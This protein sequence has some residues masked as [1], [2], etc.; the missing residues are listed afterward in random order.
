MKIVLTLKSRNEESNIQRAIESYH[1]WVDEILLADG[2]STDRTVELASQYCK[3]SVRP[4][5]EYYRREDGSL[6][7]H[8]GRHLNFLF[9]WADCVGADWIIHDDCDC[10]LNYLMKQDGRS[11][12]EACTNQTVHVCRLYVYGQDRYFR[13]MTDFAGGWQAGLWAWRADTGLR[14]KDVKR[15]FTVD[16]INQYSKCNIYPPH[17]ILHRFAP[18]EEVIQRKI[19][20]YKLEEPNATHPKRH[21]GEPEP[22]PEWARE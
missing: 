20:D 12:I 21:Y 10:S 8:E 18:T 7:N 4:F 5:L 22:L 13:T 11:I 9:D 16:D 15:H 17:C 19:A 2:G 3:V 6:R 1:D 14:S